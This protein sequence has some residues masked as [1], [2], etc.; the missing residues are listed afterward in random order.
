MAIRIRN[1]DGVTVALCAAKSQP[2]DGDIYLDDNAHHALTTKFGLDFHS[3]GFMS[4]D[5]ADEELLPIMRGEMGG[6]LV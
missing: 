1:V 4:S 5:L 6:E 3:E 2:K